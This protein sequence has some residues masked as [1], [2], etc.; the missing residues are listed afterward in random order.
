MDF[1]EDKF[2]KLEVDS[3]DLKMQQYYSKIK[4]SSKDNSSHDPEIL[5]SLIEDH[6]IDTLALRDANDTARRKISYLES[7]LVQL[8]AQKSAESNAFGHQKGE[9]STATSDLTHLSRRRERQANN[10]ITEHDGILIHRLQDELAVL[11]SQVEAESRLVKDRSDRITSLLKDNKDKD[12]KILALE[13][14]YK[15]ASAYI[16]NLETQ[17]KS[18]QPNLDIE[19]RL[20]RL[21]AESLP[22]T[23]GDITHSTIRCEEGK[24]EHQQPSSANIANQ[25]KSDYCRTGHTENP[26]RLNDR[27]LCSPGN[28]LSENVEFL[29][30]HDGRPKTTVQQASSRGI[31]SCE[32]N[33]GRERRASVDSDSRNPLTRAPH[34]SHRS[35]V[36]SN[37]GDWKVQA[38]ERDLRI[39][40]RTL[41]RLL[42]EER[43]RLRQQ[44]T[45]LVL[46]RD[47]AVEITLLEAEEI[48]RLECDLDKCHDEKENWRR[49]CRKA[50]YH[51]DQLS[52]QLRQLDLLVSHGGYSHHRVERSVS[53][54][55]QTLN[56]CEVDV[57]V[58]DATV[59]VDIRGGI[60]AYQ[61]LEMFR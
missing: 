48:V 11:V 33:K 46:V 12:L 22:I 27:F 31:V 5:T 8:R 19:R 30:S 20:H 32:T 15:K 10:A 24:A 3:F 29:R 56:N 9:S 23:Y 52:Q 39:E 50:E 21:R 7:E 17:I 4:T 18:N 49:K 25:L 60:S 58:E 36:G 16:R 1:F 34:N 37:A 59:C 28:K 41:T 44:E 35:S 57:V 13:I 42:E 43:G 14:E 61:P 51:V 38:L 55:D 2:K 45:I 6:C 54:S 26:G 47:S 40:N 53:S